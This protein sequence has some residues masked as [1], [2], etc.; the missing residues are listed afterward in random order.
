M[1]VS[2]RSASTRIVL[3]IGKLRSPRMLAANPSK[4]AGINLAH[5]VSVESDAARAP[6][7]MLCTLVAE[8]FD[9]DEWVFEPKYD[10]LRV[11][12]ESDGK[13]VR[14]TSRDGK[15]QDAQFPDVRAAALKPAHAIKRAG[16]D[17]SRL[18]TIA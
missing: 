11:L 17:R 16:I 9:S 8:P 13:R 6:R 2:T 7:L 14:L 5:K 12:V 3:V 15:S 18:S 4:P 1:A 10:G